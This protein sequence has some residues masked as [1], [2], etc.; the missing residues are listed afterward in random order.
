MAVK[1][2]KNIVFVEPH[3][4]RD[5]LV[6]LN[7]GERARYFEYSFNK[8][9]DQEEL[10]FPIIKE[11]PDEYSWASSA[12]V[13]Y[14]TVTSKKAKWKNYKNGQF[15]QVFKVTIK[16][17]ILSCGE[18]QDFLT[19][20]ANKIS[21]PIVGH[22]LNHCHAY[23]KKFTPISSADRTN[24]INAQVLTDKLGVVI[25]LG[26]FVA[27]PSGSSGGSS[28]VNILEVTS[29]GIGT[30]NGLQADRLI[31][32]RTNNANKQLGW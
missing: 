6:N 30:V 12:E 25:E 13:F 21:T 8:E 26:D 29:F 28:S 2:F 20:I 14:Y 7:N 23:S 5:T 32:V 4:W 31:V 24:I 1:M 9:S 11:V 15:K 19:S 3:K 18:F 22:E 27:H 16:I 10:N 17:A